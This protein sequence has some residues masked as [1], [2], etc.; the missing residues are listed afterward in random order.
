MSDKE[1][2]EILSN[3]NPCAHCPSSGYDCADNH[4]VIVEA[5]NQCI[6]KLSGNKSE[7]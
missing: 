3:Y 5:I 2:I 6:L 7:G 4:C 1:I